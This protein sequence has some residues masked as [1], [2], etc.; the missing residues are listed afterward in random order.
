MGDQLITIVQATEDVSNTIMSPVDENE[1]LLAHLRDGMDA[2]AKLDII[3]KI[4]AS[5]LGLFEC[6]FFQDITGQPINRVV[7]VFTDFEPGD[8]AHKC[9]RN[10]A[11]KT[12]VKPAQ[13][14]TEDEK[15]LNSQHRDGEVMSQSEICA[16]F[17]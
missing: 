4:T 10:G 1:R 16:L 15:L 2:A 9:G 17:D 11:Q 3:D 12:T 5:I 13:E 6:Y 8:R 7:K 14:K